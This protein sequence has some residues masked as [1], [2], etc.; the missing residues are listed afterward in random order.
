MFEDEETRAFYESLVDL[1]AV[2]PAVLLGEKTAKEEAGA[3]L[4]GGGGEAAAEADAGSAAPT[5]VQKAGSKQD[6]GYDDILEERAL[7]WD[8]FCHRRWCGAGKAAQEK[9]CL[10]PPLTS[11]PPR[12]PA[13]P[14]SPSLTPAGQGRRGGSGAQPAGPASGAAAR[15]RQQG[16]GG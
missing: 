14:S 16:A 8:W 10:K 4:G 13:A 7:V 9:T 1:R 5:A 6:L 3:A 11:H 12:D 2:V 15:L